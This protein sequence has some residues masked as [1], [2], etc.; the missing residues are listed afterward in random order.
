MK[1]AVHSKAAA[2][3]SGTF[4]KVWVCSWETMV[5]GVEVLALTEAPEMALKVVSE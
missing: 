2:L 3:S 4:V 5:Q 1:E